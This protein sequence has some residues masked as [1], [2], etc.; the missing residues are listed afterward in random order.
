MFDLKEFFESNIDEAFDKFMNMTGEECK[1][2]MTGIFL[3]FGMSE[4]L[5]EKESERRKYRNKT[6]GYT[7]YNDV[8]NARSDSSRQNFRKIRLV[9]Y[10][11]ENAQDVL[12]DIREKIATTGLATVK[13]LYEASDMPTNPTMSNW[14]WDDVEDA[15][16]EPAGNNYYTL[17][18]PPANPFIGSTPHPKQTS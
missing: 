16:I 8:Y 15:H 10:T 14:F 12:V 5:N 2:M 11:K 18:M 1:A 17:C 6:N 4:I 13:D 7:R 9:F 3:G